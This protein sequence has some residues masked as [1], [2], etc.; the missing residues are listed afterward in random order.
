MWRLRIV[1]LI[2]FCAC[3]VYSSCHQTKYIDHLDTVSQKIYGDSIPEN[4]ALDSLINPYKR[5][6]KQKMFDTLAYNSKDLTR[7]G[8]EG[9]LG[10]WVA[11]ALVWHADSILNLNIDF[12]LV[13]SGGLRIRKLEK[14]PVLRKNI[15]ELMPFDNT[16]VVVEVDSATM[17]SI[18]SFAAHGWPISRRYHIQLNAENDRLTWSIQKKSS[19]KNFRVI[20]SSFLASGGDKMNFL[21]PQKQEQTNVL[22]R[23]ALILYAQHQKNLTAKVEGRISKK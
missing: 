15:Y 19:G 2:V 17:D 8:R 11:D 23:D 20:L 1:S 14:G 6:Y 10:N 21:I 4:A 22:L 7:E 18:S 5:I 3:I 12:S 13:N 9:T 16:L